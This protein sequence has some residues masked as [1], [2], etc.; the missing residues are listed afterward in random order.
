VGGTRRRLATAEGAR[1]PM[2]Q[3]HSA[4]AGADGLSLSLAGDAPTDPQDRRAPPLDARLPGRAVVMA[5]SVE[6]KGPITYSAVL[7]PGEDGWICAQIAEVPEAISQ[8]R[9]LEEAKANVTE[10]LALEWRGSRRR[11][12]ARGLRCSGPP[13]GHPLHVGGRS[14]TP[15]PPSSASP[16]AGENR[17]GLP[18]PHWSSSVG[19]GRSHS[20][21]AQVGHPK[22]GCAGGQ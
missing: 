11:A 13:R 3:A 10:A 17:A 16:R 15:V 18:C 1:A 6:D 19:L 4:M 8:V 2:R 14:R 20:R 21:A 7:T 5:E 9:T 12:D 22:P